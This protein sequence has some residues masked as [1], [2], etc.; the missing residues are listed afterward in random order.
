MYSVSLGENVAMNMMCRDESSGLIM[1]VLF[2]KEI[3][4]PH[5]T[6]SSLN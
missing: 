5:T 6:Y 2:K 4:I 3:K 1:S